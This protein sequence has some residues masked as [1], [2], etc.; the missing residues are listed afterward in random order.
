[1][2]V[3]ERLMILEDLGARIPYGLEVRYEYEENKFVYD[4]LVSVSIDEGYE[5]VLKNYYFHVDDMEFVKPYLYSESELTDDMKDDAVEHKAAKYLD[6]QKKY[7]VF[8]NDINTVKW[9][10]QNKV[11]YRN[12]IA[13]GFALPMK[14]K[15]VL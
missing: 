13:K 3:E 14:E 12:L 7:F 11:D 5:Y 1:M 15:P 10:N 8:N 9:C 4:T 6:P 2:T